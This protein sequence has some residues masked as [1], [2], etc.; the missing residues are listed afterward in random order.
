MVYQEKGAERIE[1]AASYRVES[2][3]VGFE[4]EDYD[5]DLP[6]IIDP[7]LSYAAYWGTADHEHAFALTVDQQGAPFTGASGALTADENGPGDFNVFITKFE[8]DGQ[9]VAFTTFF[10]GARDEWGLGITVDA[11]G[12]PY[13][14]G[15]T[16][17]EDFPIERGFQTE[18]GGAGPT[19]GVD[20]F[21]TQLSADGSTVLYSTYLGGSSD[22]GAR[23]IAVD[24]AGDILVAG[25]TASPDF[26]TQ[27]ALQPQN[28]G[29]EQFGTDGF[30]AK[31]SG[32]TGQLI[33]S[34]YLGGRDD[35]SVTALTVD[36]AGEVLL[37]GVTASDDFPLVQPLQG[38][39]G[40]A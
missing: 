11:Q 9:T 15:M 22:D 32:T 8:P 25:G 24:A 29:G 27:N 14:T 18:F 35:D 3:A 20:A 4:L 36:S 38:Q 26:P 28:A 6:L 33:Y 2:G 10:G 16:G 1:I 37:A 21:V 30:A 23:G 5:R 40:G 12:R 13:V 17:S 7:L 19:F 39:L 34:T 31:L